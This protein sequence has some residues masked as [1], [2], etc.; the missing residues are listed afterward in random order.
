MY[1]LSASSAVPDLPAGCSISFPA[2][3]S[4]LAPTGP[5]SGKRAYLYYGLN[6]GGIDQWSTPPLSDLVSGLRLA[7]DEVV[8]ASEAEPQVNLCA[9]TNG[10]WQMREMFNASLNTLLDTIEAAHGPATN[11]IG[12]ISFGGLHAMMG[13]ASNGRFSAWFA[14]V[15]VTRLDALTEFAG[16]GE[17][18]RFNPFH[19]VGALALKTG[20]ISWGTADTRVDWTLTKAL[21][22]LLPSTVTKKEWT[23]QAHTTTSANVTDMLNWVGGV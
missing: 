17:V 10:G 14:H 5:S 1:L 13:S 21:A 18:A 9:Y 11:I 22:D 3:Y 15:P 19:D 7:G 4:Y 6:S 12:G 8:L 2:T 23:G 20:Y 16:V